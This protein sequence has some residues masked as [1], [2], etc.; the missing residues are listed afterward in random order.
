MRR[1]LAYAHRTDIPEALDFIDLVIAAV[2]AD[3]P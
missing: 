3:A 2:E 1:R